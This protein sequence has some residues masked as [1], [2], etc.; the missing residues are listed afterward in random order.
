M[1]GATLKKIVEGLKDI[2]KQVNWNCTSDG[3]SLQVMIISWQSL[4]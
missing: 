1:K 3:I 2:V 4:L